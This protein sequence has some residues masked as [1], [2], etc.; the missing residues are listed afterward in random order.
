MFP[1]NKW[2]MEN[3]LPTRQET[4]G[5]SLGQE[6]P[7]EKGMATHS[8]FLPGDRQEEHR[9]SSIAGCRP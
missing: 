3:N 5:R 9:Q 6:D 2:K 4:Q 7:Q 8:V 1:G